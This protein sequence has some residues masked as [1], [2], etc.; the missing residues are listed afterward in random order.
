MVPEFVHAFVFRAHY[1][2]GG[3]PS[4]LQLLIRVALV[5]EA[6]GSDQ[7]CRGGPQPGFFTGKLKGE[8]SP[9]A[10][11]V[12]NHSGTIRGEL[13]GLSWCSRSNALT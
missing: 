8:S 2:R 10:G 1:V 9:F 13:G 4:G 5:L 3:G 7:Q 12:T 11:T 6:A